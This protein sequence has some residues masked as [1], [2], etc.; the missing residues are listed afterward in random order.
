MLSLNLQFLWPLTRT[1]DFCFCAQ[2]GAQTC[3]TVQDAPRPQEGT[4]FTLKPDKLHH[5]IIPSKYKQKTPLWLY[6]FIF[7]YLLFHIWDG[8]DNYHLWTAK[9]K[10]WL[11]SGNPHMNE[12]RPL[13]ERPSQAQLL[14]MPPVNKHD[15][16][17]HPEYEFVFYHWS[18]WTLIT[19]QWEV[20]L[21]LLFIIYS[22]SPPPEYMFCEYNDLVYLVR[23]WVH[24]S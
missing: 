12:H 24:G 9:E 21:F 1:L 2:G 15:P 20:I 17:V 22:L 19:S 6:N 3:Y 11:F 14:K 18:Q 4:S 7:S 23:Y 13:S 8:I 16:Q 10:Q 5:E